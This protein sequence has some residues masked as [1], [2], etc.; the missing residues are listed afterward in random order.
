MNGERESAA[1]LMYFVLIVPISTPPTPLLR[2]TLTG[3]FF[4][5]MILPR[6][7]CLIVTGFSDSE[8]KQAKRQENWD[9]ESCEACYGKRSSD[10][11]AHRQHGEAI[12][13]ARDRSFISKFCS[14]SKT[15]CRI[16]QETDTM[17]LALRHDSILGRSHAAAV[18]GRG[19]GRFSSRQFHFCKSLSLSAYF[20]PPACCCCCS[21]GPDPC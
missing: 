18:A 20:P 8:T 14:A 3:V 11:A 10:V 7:G 5:R 9:P 16:S 2:L 1:S 12:K 4:L 17:L 13:R 15:Y 19:R 21:C 6:K